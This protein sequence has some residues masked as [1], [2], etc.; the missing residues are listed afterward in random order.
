MQCVQ[1]NISSNTLN[2]S[3]HRF[4][5]IPSPPQVKTEVAYSPYY[6]D[7]TL[8]VQHRVIFIKLLDQNYYSTKVC[9]TFGSLKSYK[10]F[11]QFALLIRTLYEKW[12]QNHVIK[13]IYSPLADKR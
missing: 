11:V 10:C 1:L 6:Y 4:R 3:M 9:C 5:A 13:P 8:E 12:I 7:S 2:L